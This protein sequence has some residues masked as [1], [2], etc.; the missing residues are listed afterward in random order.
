MTLRGKVIASLG[1]G[2][3][4][5]VASIFLGIAFGLQGFPRVATALLWPVRAVMPFA[6]CLPRGDPYCEGSL[7]V[8][9]MYRWSVALALSA[10][11]VSAYLLISVATSVRTR[12]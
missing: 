6:P 8:G 5:S 11:S 7:F 9:H 12:R 4:I 3:A 1:I 2:I 10:Y